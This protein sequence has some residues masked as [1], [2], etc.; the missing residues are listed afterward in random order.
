MECQEWLHAISEAA[1]NELIFDLMWVA[2]WGF[3]T[4]LGL[5]WAKTRPYKHIEDDAAHFFAWLCTWCVPV[6]A[7]FVSL[8]MFSGFLGGVHLT[9]HP[10]D[11][12]HAHYYCSQ[13]AHREVVVEEAK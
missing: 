3:F 5:K 9:F 4:Y 2:I 6:I 11:E 7:F 12:A 8:G 13:W 10:I 1:E